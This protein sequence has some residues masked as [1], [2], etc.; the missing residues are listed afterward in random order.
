[1]KPFPCKI[2]EVLK[3]LRSARD[4]LRAEF[5]DLRFALDGNLIGDIGEAIAVSDFGLE[6]LNPGSKQHDCKTKSGK[7]VQVKTTQQI[8]P[9]KAV[10]LGLTKR[11]FDHLLVIQLLD[12][13]YEILYNGPGSYVDKARAH[14]ESASLSVRQ[15]SVL[16]DKAKLHRIRPL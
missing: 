2:G 7:L 9:G 16:N 3:K 8:T 13:G 1:M 15:L 5:P 11:T 14:K 6:K 4:E 12:C 10:G